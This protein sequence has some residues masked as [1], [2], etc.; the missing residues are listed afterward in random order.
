VS[1]MWIIL[2]IMLFEFSGLYLG[3]CRGRFLP[4]QVLLVFSSNH[5]GME[6]GPLQGKVTCSHLV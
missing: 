4:E 5:E 6:E 2:K 1:A 3:T